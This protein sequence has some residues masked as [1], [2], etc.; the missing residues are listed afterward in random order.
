M[1]DYFDRVERQ[2]VQ[3][4]EALYSPSAGGSLLAR[5]PSRS[6]LSRASALLNALGLSRARAVL[7]RPSRSV[8]ATIMGVLGG[9][10]AALIVSLGASPATPDFTIARGKGGVVTIKATTPSSIAAVNARLAS[11][12]I[13]I[14]VARVLPRCVAPVRPVGARRRSARARTLDLASMP[15]AVRRLTNDRQALVA[16]RIAPPTTRGQ[17]LLLAAGTSGTASFGQLISG[18]APACI[19]GPA[20]GHALLGAPS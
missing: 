2:L 10:V 12:G 14:R 9:L 3:R 17:T 5:Q 11:L 1:S 13:A 18:L 8:A 4:A 19:R 6:Y 16:V 15:V 7:R 20:Q